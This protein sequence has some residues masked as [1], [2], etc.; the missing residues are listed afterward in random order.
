LVVSGSSFGADFGVPFGF[1]MPVFF[2]RTIL[3]VARSRCNESQAAT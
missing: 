3:I 2:V 1:A